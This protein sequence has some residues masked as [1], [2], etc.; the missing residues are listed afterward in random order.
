MNRE[1][2]IRKWATIQ[3]SILN[4]QTMKNKAYTK[5]PDDEK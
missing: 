2:L 3:Q 4:R 1:N 5:P